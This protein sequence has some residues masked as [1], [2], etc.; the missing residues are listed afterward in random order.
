ME[1]RNKR[2][3]KSGPQQVS[4]AMRNDLD[5]WA[6]AKDVLDRLLAGDKDYAAL[7]PDHWA[8]AHP[9]CVRTYRADER[10]ERAES[11]QARR[12]DRRAAAR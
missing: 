2:L 5:P 11:K 3:K 12:A 1:S 8:Q 4:S 9:E 6:Y 10:R 7:R